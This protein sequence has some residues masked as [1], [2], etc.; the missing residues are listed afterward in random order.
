MAAHADLVHRAAALG[1]AEIYLT[2]P[3]HWFKELIDQAAAAPL[4]VNVR[5]GQPDACPILLSLRQYEALTASNP[6]N[7]GA[8]TP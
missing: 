8:A 5:G 1:A 3:P 4:L 2:Q 7:V 6:P